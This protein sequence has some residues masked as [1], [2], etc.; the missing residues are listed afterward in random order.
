LVTPSISFFTQPFFFFFCKKTADGISIPSGY[1]SFVAPL[2]SSKIYSRVLEL[3]KFETPY[4]VMIHAA[5][6]ISAP[7]GG[8][9]GEMEKVQETWSFAHPRTDLVFSP[10]TGALH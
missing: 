8:P 10:I 5:E 4:V 6:I 2:A 1:C 9:E 7:G 3:G